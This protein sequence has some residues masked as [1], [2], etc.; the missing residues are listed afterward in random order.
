MGALLKAVSPIKTSKEFVFDMGIILIRKKLRSLIILFCVSL[1]FC[2][3]A[4]T[5]KQ[6]LISDLAN[7]TEEVKTYGA[8]YSEDDWK[9]V[10]EELDAIEK[11]IEL[12][13]DEYTNEELK[14]IGRLKGILF[15]Q[16]TKNTVMSIKERAESA[17]NETEGLIEG[18]L[19]SFNNKSSE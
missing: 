11:E 7:L 12:H 18:F 17:V 13:K 5:T 16:Y 4:C 1:F 19:N 2:L 15:A 6:G 10:A 14:E 9:S 3:S 8:S